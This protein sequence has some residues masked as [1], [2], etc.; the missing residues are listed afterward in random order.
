M[1]SLESLL[2]P[3]S[4]EE[5]QAPHL[6]LWFLLARQGFSKPKTAEEAGEL[7]DRAGDLRFL[8]KASALGRFIKE[9]GPD[10][11]LYEALMEG[12]GYH[13]NRQP[14]L[15][16]AYLA[17]YSVLKRAAEQLPENGRAEAITGWLLAV[18][19]LV[20]P[21]NAAMRPVRPG[22]RRVM[23]KAQW[24]LFRVRPSNHPIVRVAGAGEL[25]NR[26]LG[27]GLVNGLGQ[28]VE[29]VVPSV[30]IN[31]LTVKYPG[32]AASIGAGRAKDLAV[33]AVLPF[34][35]ANCGENTGQVYLSLFQRFPRLE[36]NEIVREMATELLPED[37]HC[38]VNSAQRQ[39]GLLHL[40]AL[41]KGA[42]QTPQTEPA[43]SGPA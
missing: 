28:A 2:A 4:P 17:P 18:S 6:D 5:E 27:P 41:L 14:F 26:F 31:A 16:L 29:A 8:G 13:H 22:L 43:P 1:V 42:N 19:G 34:L 35:Y 7:L 39:Q 10:Q 38:Q 9:Q 24:H 11:T 23:A 32:Q 12:L 33:N 25:I 30:L 15:R 21:F 3:P 20:E 40:A 36:D 37:W